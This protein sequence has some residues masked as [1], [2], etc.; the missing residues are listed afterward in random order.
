MKKRRSKLIVMAAVM[1]LVMLT[2]I[3][4]SLVACE[5]NHEH[6]FAA[7]WTSDETGH[8]HKSTCN[9]DVVD[10]KEAHTFGNWKEV[11]PAT[12]Q[13]DGE[14]QRTC[15]VCGY[16]QKQA[17]PQLDHTHTFEKGWTSDETGHWHKSTCNHDVVDGKEAHTF[18]NWKEVRPATEQQDGEQQRTCSVCGYIQKQAIP[19]L[20]HTHKFE[21][22]WTKDDTSHWHAATCGHSDK[23]GEEAHIY[24]STA[25]STCTCTVCG[26]VH[27]HTYSETEWESNGTSHW[28]KVTCGHADAPHKDEAFHDYGNSSGDTYFCGVCQY[29]HKHS[30]SD[31][32]SSDVTGHWHAAT[33]HPTERADF[34]S[35][36][37][38]AGGQCK[39][40][41]FTNKITFGSYPQSQVKDTELC[42]ALTEQAG[43]LPTSSNSN[44]W[45]DYGYYI[46]AKIKSYMWYKDLTYGG[47]N[48]RGVYFTEYRQYETYH[49]CGSYQDDNGFNI[50]ILYWFKFEPITWRIITSTDDR[51]LLMSD[52]IIDCRD[53]CSKGD[54]E[55]LGQTVRAN[56]YEYS[57]I[58]KWLNDNFYNTAFNV[59]EQQSIVQTL[60]DNSASTTSQPDSTHNY[61]CK[62]TFDNI[63]LLSW[64][65]VNS[66]TYG[67]TAQS[68]MLKATAYAQCQG[69]E[70]YD[71]IGYWWLRSP[72]Q[73]YGSKDETSF[74]DGSGKISSYK[75]DYYCIGVVPGMWITAE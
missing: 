63:F 72:R 22:G 58:R 16:I 42:N 25:G 43:A 21:Q 64:K 31:T 60:V 37:Y 7:D 46:A 67:L 33:C 27:S 70:T 28:R 53:F 10:G 2:T 24:A 59:T 6:T 40:C 48:Y 11:R 45:T 69:M 50:K 49:Y 14:Q 54:R 66:N 3:A 61:T 29:A 65:D 26:Y 32:W 19:Q 8:W 39:D 47:E 34:T 17:I 73:S 9:H 1:V 62:D 57:E 51:M 4:F 44:G 5:S 56:N 36:A 38:D 18:G 35:H 68:L 20:D 12:E 15:S 71:N 23:Q 30:Y 74:V 41:K 52:S 75:T 13:Q 55:V